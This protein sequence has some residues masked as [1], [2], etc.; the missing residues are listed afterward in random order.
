MLAIGRALMASPKLLLLD[1]PSLGLAPQLVER[2]GEVVREINAQGT[3][4]LLVEQNA[5]MALEVADS[6][7][8]ARGRPG[9]RSTGTAAELAASD[10]VRE[11][12]LGIGGATAAAEPDRRPSGD[13]TAA[14]RRE[15]AR[16]SAVERRS[17]CASA[18]SRRSSDVSLRRR[19]RHGARAD[20]AQ[21]RRQ[22]DAAST[23]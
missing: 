6:A 11:R 17:P 19:A 23:C 16:S 7:V 8:R 9:R 18:A 2:I 13:A 5:A 3:A 21:R 4:V 12:Y 1:E 14:G 15:R 22:V 20:R 10:E